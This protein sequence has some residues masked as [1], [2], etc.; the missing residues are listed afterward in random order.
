M[1][2]RASKAATVLIVEDDHDLAQLIQLHL[3]EVGVTT[4]VAHSAAQTLESLASHPVDLILLDLG[5][6]DMNGAELVLVLQQRG[7]QTPFVVV[8]GW[9]DQQTTVELMKR[10]ARDYVIK[11][12]AFLDM[13]PS[14]TLQTLAQIDRDQ[15]LAQAERQIREQNQFLESVL[16]SL[17]HPLYV[18]DAESYTV[19]TANLAAGQARTNAPAG[20]EVRPI[21]Q[22]AMENGA[23]ID[24][25]VED[26]KR[27][28]KA[29]IIEHVSYDEHGQATIHEIHMCPIFD[30]RGAV[31]Q[32]IEYDLDVTVHKQIEQALRD[33]EARLRQVVESL[34]I[35]LASHDP[36]GRINL[37]IGAV[38]ELLGYE[39]Q[40]FVDDPRF[41]VKIIHPDD[42]EQVRSMARAGMAE[43]RPTELDFRV[44]HGTDQRDVW[45]HVEVVPVCDEEGA[46]VRID[47]ITV[48]QTEEKRMAVEHERLEEHLQRTQ[49]LESLGTLAGGVAHDFNNLLTIISGNAQFLKAST[50]L[51]PS[52]AKALADIEFATENAIDVARSLEAFSV[53]SKPQ[54]T[55]IDAN[56]LIQDVYRFL[57]RLIPAR[58]EFE[59]RPCAAVCMMAADPSQLQQV[60]VNLC[61][62]A[63]DAI[64]GQGRLEIRTRQ[65]KPEEL[66]LRLRAGEQNQRYIEIV[67]K[68]T[69]CGMDE[70][71]QRQAFD[72]FFTTKPKDQGTGLGLAIVH[73]IV[74]TH[75]GV[76]EVN[77]SP[78]HGTEFRIYLPQC[79]PAPAESSVVLTSAHGTERVLVVDDE[80]MIASLL[81]TLLERSGYRVAM[82][83]HPDEAI[84]IAAA[85]SEPFN[86]VVIDYSLPGMP[87]DVCLA[88]LRQKWPKLKAILI[89]GYQVDTGEMNLEDVRIL[90]KPF[91][92]QAILRAVREVLDESV[93]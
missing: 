40:Q 3:T 79:A 65:A 27:T 85:A 2:E 9:D 89:T 30:E 42:L 63:R 66:P 5:L 22:P 47:S 80:A 8:S 91:S 1:N 53:P 26:V 37:L 33:S 43:Q 7:L 51:T 28:G 24:S 39:P 81:H 16:N 17:P 19:E 60:L 13:L 12:A 83:H 62:N 20:G 25:P 86:L 70:V 59:F 15:R 45:L 54:I 32:V 76:I 72:P 55:H 29:Q 6:P 21:W 41:H 31:K 61:V 49:R 87:G 38:K 23:P 69:G 74:E 50:E 67:V 46:L 77:S 56:V 52:Q 11:D 88:K 58:I 71:A 14:V 90:A 68:D 36:Q 10:G 78:G 93:A 35:I 75:G 18:I 48:D 73:R 57:R 84:A 4:L 64:R 92:S 44:R 34:P 82:A